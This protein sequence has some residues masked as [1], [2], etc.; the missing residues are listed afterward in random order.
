MKRVSLIRQTK[1]GNIRYYRIELFLTLFGDYILER[2]YGNIRYK[3]PTGIRKNYFA[4]F[5]EAIAQYDKIIKQKIRK[6][7]KYQYA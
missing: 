5:D 7:Y 2:E 6:G 4:R 1:K 3:G